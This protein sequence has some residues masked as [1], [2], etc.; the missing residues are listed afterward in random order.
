MF[1]KSIGLVIALGSTACPAHAMHF[2]VTV[3]I[4]PVLREVS[5]LLVRMG[6]TGAG[7][8]LVAGGTLSFYQMVKNQQDRPDIPPEACL[9][10]TRDR[11]LLP[12][13]GLIGLGLSC[14]LCAPRVKLFVHV[15]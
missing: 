14:I 2:G 6:L 9:A 13:I 15:Y 3:D 8:M 12:A 11:R 10:D 7:L 5:D 1:F 4:S